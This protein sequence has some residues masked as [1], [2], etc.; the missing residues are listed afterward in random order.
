[1]CMLPLLAIGLGVAAVSAGV[2]AARSGVFLSRAKREL[3]D[4]ERTPI[5]P[6]SVSPEMR[7]FYGQALEETRNPRGVSAAERLS[8]NQNLAKQTGTM[9]N[10]AIA[11]SG[12]NMARAIRG[13]L[14]TATLGQ[15][16]QFAQFDASQKRL[17]RQSAF[18]RLSFA[19]G[20]MQR[21]T[22]M[23]EQANIDAQRQ[24]GMAIMTQRENIGKAIGSVGALGGMLAGYSMGT[25][26]F[27]SGF[28]SGSPQG[29]S[30]P[31]AAPPMWDGSRGM[32]TLPNQSPYPYNPY[33]YGGSN[34]MIG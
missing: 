16:N 34:T 22:N 7:S 11:M 21:I 12:G 20:Q 5:S 9:Y 17:N 13:G 10:N 24:L 27:G 28:G 33:Q 25:N 3:R 14:N 4:L 26:N 6:Y 18:G 23:N 2:N 31:V 29:M 15:V 19:T 32:R 8:F 30:Q 1:M